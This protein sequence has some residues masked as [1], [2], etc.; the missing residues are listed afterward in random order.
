MTY[1]EILLQPDTNDDNYIIEDIIHYSKEVL[2]QH[3]LPYSLKDTMDGPKSLPVF[4]EHF[5][6]AMEI[7]NSSECMATMSEKEKHL[8]WDYLNY[9]GIVNTI[10]FNYPDYNDAEVDAAAKLEYELNSMYQTPEL[11]VRSLSDW[12][13]AEVLKYEKSSCY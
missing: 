2:K 11:V 8:Y 4:D 6:S 1:R 10:M 12:A 9:Q 13:Y 3:N 5:L 7:A